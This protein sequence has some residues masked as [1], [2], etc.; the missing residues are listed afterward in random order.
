VIDTK[1]MIVGKIFIEAYSS[2][3]DAQ[4]LLSFADNL[5]NNGLLP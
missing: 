4:S 5:L 3:V 2:R 1:G